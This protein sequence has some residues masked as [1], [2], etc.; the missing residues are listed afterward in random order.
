MLLNFSKQLYEQVPEEKIIPESQLSEQEK[1]NYFINK[2]DGEFEKVV[3][4]IGELE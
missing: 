1:L 2:K 4:M 3:E